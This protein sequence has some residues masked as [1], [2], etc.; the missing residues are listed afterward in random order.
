MH[1]ARASFAA[2]TVLATVPFGTAASGQPTLDRV[3]SVPEDRS[4]PDAPPAREPLKLDVE[5]PRAASASK[6]T[7]EVGA[8]ALKGLRTLAPADFA[9]ILATRIGR[10]LDPAD[11]SALATALAQRAR[12]RGFVFATAWIEA[13]QLRNG[14]LVVCLDEGTVDEIRVEG[15]EQ[16]AVRAAL[17]PL[18]TGK[19]LKIGELQRRLLL[20]G[21][22]DGVKIRSSRFLREGGK[23]VLVVLL[24]LDRIAGRATL[25]NEG[26]R[27]IGPEQLTLH[28]D[29]NSLLAADDALSVTWSQTAL[30]PGE[31]HF[32]RLRYEKRVDRSGTEVALAGSVSSS[33]P[34]AYLD[35]LNIHSRSWSIG[36]SVLQPLLRRRARSL[37]FQA[38]LGVRDLRQ[39]RAGVLAR[40]ERVVTARGTLYGYTDLAGGRLRANLALV[41][42]LGI[43]NAS[44]AGNPFASRRDADGTFTTLAAWSDWTRPLGAA[45]SI[46]LAMQ[47]QLASEALPVS[48]E[49]GLGGTSFL[50]GYDWFERGGDE[51]V[52]GLAELRYAWD[53]PLGLIRRAQ[54]YAFVDGGEV[55]N[56]DGGYGSGSL[57]SAGSGIRADLTRTFGAS[58]ELA[59]P[60][61][62]PRYDTEDRTPKFNFRLQKSF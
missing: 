50:R 43:L 55:S 46:R 9:D 36:A 23:G 62:G 44:Q 61:S 14:V 25:A 52:M 21:D 35:A 42:G 15:G 8:I 48:E 33:R 3:Q 2:L 11:I 6:R 28:V 49:I 7:V 57:A 51:G 37:W 1:P 26:T 10:S 45:F 54:L 56:R 18:V 60:L 12:D 34:G 29:F 16:P 17:A 39:T 38:E 27:P 58:L 31:M 13:Q 5:A 40:D 4:A 32:G 30:Q 47:G 22:I 41:Q 53:H 24:A 19:P 20:A 59:V